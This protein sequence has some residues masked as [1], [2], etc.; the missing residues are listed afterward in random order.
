MRK[1]VDF[2][3]RWYFSFYK[4]LWPLTFKISFSFWTVLYKYLQEVAITLKLQINP[5]HF[6]LKR[7][8]IDSTIWY[9]IPFTY[10]HCVNANMRYSFQMICSLPC[11]N[12]NMHLHIYVI[13]TFSFFLD[14]LRTFDEKSRCGSKRR[15][16]VIGRNT[17]LGLVLLKIHQPHP[18]PLYIENK[19][20]SLSS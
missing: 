18:S 9:F 12:D 5:A 17:R 11:K 13:N 20:S 3:P 14:V 6:Y 4:T 8:S 15:N 7:N 2:L 10:F 19:H 1:C 16:E